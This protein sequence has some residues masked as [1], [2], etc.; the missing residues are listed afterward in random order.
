MRIAEGFDTL[1]L[2]LAV[3]GLEGAGFTVLTPGRHLDSVLP[4]T[5]AALGPVPILVPEP[6]AA[7]GMAFLRAI[8]AEG[9]RVLAEARY[10][11]GQ[12]PAGPAPQPPGLL[13]RLWRRL[14]GMPPPPSAPPPSAPARRPHLRVVPPR[15]PPDE[16]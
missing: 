6:Q 11:P 1:G 3:T 4:N 12:D 16:G 13:A 2:T 14:L 9:V 10:L 15:Q 7:E 8:G 5:S